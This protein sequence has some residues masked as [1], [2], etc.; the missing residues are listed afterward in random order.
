MNSRLQDVRDSALDSIRMALRG[1]NIE[2][3]EA[4]DIDPGSSPII[5]EDPFDDNNTYTLD[6]IILDGET[7]YFD[8]SNASQNCSW[9]DANIPTDALLDIADYLDMYAD[10]IREYVYGKE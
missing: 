1:N 6:R 4:Y 3:I 7:I 8:G 2:L 10:E 9:N 5:Q